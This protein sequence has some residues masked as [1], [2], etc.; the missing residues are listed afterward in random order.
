M[1]TVKSRSPGMCLR[2]FR[3]LRKHLR[4]LLLFRRLLRLLTRGKLLRMTRNLRT[5]PDRLLLLP[6]LFSSPRLDLFINR[7]SQ[8]PSA[9]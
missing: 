5:H 3:T 7:L 4:Q 6:S 1:L 8:S 2:M 9:S